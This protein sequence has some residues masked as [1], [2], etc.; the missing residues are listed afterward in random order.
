MRKNKGKFT[1]DYKGVCWVKKVRKWSTSLSK[2]K[3][4]YYLGDYT[5]ENNAIK[6]HK[7]FKKKLKGLK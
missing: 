6:A 3:K 1:S 7:A 2:N 5:T 4:R